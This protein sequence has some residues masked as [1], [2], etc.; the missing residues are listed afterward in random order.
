MRRTIFCAALSLSACAMMSQRDYARSI[1]VGHVGCPER[2]IQ[3]VGEPDVGPMESL[4]S[5]E[6]SC[7]GNTYYCSK[8]GDFDG[9]VRC[10]KGDRQIADDVAE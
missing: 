4:R 10:V 6:V 2:E 1:T 9:V 3:V 8:S 7:R 5:W